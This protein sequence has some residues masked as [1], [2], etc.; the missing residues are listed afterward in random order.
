MTRQTSIAAML[1]T[2]LMCALLGCGGPTPVPSPVRSPVPSATRSIDSDKPIDQVRKIVAELFGV[3][4]SKVK[5]TTTMGDLGAD[6]L[7]FVELVMELEEAFD[8]TIEDSDL[9]KGAGTPEFLVGMKKISIQKL[10]EIVE[11]RKTSNSPGEADKGNTAPANEAA[12][13]IANPLDEKSAPIIAVWDDS[14]EKS[15]EVNGPYL[16]LAIWADGR[17]V[18]ARD[19]NQWSQDLQIGRISGKAMEELTGKILKTGVF[20]LK[21]DE[22]LVPDA[23][24]HKMLLSIAGW[25]K[26]LGWDEVDMEHYGISVNPNPDSNAFKKAWREVNLLAVAALPKESE[27]LNKRFENPPRDWYRKEAIGTK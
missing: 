20:E 2:A 22:Y 23:P 11:A 25:R 3:D 18:F 10:A 12:G 26:V 27:K 4:P 1:V 9:E 8:I 17:V 6:D 16:R 24:S 19:P 15:G 14:L 21:R 5:P 13:A 7:D